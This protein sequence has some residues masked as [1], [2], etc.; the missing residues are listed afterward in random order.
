MGEGCVKQSLEEKDHE[1]WRRKG[2]KVSNVA[3]ACVI[4]LF[5]EPSFLAWPSRL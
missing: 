3:I 2:G 4:E 5:P 1:A